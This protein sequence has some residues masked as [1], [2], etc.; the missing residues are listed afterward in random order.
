[1]SHDLSLVRS[2]YVSTLFCLWHRHS[3]LQYHIIYVIHFK[4]LNE[5]AVVSTLE[6]MVLYV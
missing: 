2:F 3:Q 6:F 4:A 5:K 1:M